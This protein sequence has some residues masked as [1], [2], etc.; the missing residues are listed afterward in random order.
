MLKQLLIFW[1]AIVFAGSLSAQTADFDLTIAITKV[2]TN[3]PGTNEPAITY[4]KSGKHPFY[5]LLTNKSGVTK[6]LWQ[7]WYSWGY[8]NL[9]FEFTDRTGRTWTVRRSYDRASSIDGPGWF[10]LEPGE[11]HVFKVTF[12]DD[13]Q[14]LPKVDNPPPSYATYVTIRAIYEIQPDGMIQRGGVQMMGTTTKDNGVWTGKA[15]S[16]AVDVHLFDPK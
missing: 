12:P 1:L 9:Y 10:E 14:D 16:N 3:G 8:W 11:T 13:W 7:E 5:V 2:N 4:D 15:I 6:H